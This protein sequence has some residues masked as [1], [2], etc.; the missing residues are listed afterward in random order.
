[1]QM[2]MWGEMMP[3]RGQ[4]EFS[5]RI[6]LDALGLLGSAA[7]HIFVMVSCLYVCLDW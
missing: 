4:L 7:D 3:K 5:S 1:V 2:H 6:S